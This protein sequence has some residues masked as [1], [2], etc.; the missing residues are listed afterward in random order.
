MTKYFQK[1]KNPIKCHT[2]S[3]HRLYLQLSSLT[4]S[5]QSKAMTSMQPTILTVQQYAESF[6]PSLIRELK[7]ELGFTLRDAKKVGEN[8]IHKLKSKF[9][10]NKPQPILVFQEASVTIVSWETN[11]FKRLMDKNFGLSEGSF[12]EM[13][14]HLQAGDEHLYEK[15]FLHHFDSCLVFVKRKYNASHADAYD[16]SM[17]AMLVF[18][19]KLKEG[20]IQYGNL[21]FLFTQMAGQIYLKWIRRESKTEEFFEIELFEEPERFDKETIKI[22]GDAFAKLG[23]GCSELL[24]GFYYNENTLQDIAGNSDK[25]PAAIRKQKQRCIE[26]L[27]NFFADLS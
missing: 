1:I 23:D 16:A 3:P 4:K 8:V 22:L 20:N 7:E 26:K 6:F 27:R 14:E 10:A 21:R 12:S 18:C 15:V 5:A 2:P 9:K 11:K 25:S 24:K 17:D 19:R 13:V